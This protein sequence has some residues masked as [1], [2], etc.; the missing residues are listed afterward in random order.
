MAIKYGGPLFSITI[1]AILYFAVAGTRVSG[2]DLKTV[3]LILMVI[4][5][6]GLLLAIIVAAMNRPKPPSNQPPYQG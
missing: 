4:G 3:G 5:L 2:V 1:G 6:V